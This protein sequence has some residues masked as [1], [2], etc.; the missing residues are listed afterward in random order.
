MVVVLCFVGIIR[1]LAVFGK[2][3]DACYGVLMGFV[4]DSNIVDITDT[5]PIH[6]STVE[7]RVGTHR[8]HLVVVCLRAQPLVIVALLGY[9]KVTGKQEE[10]DE[11][12]KSRKGGKVESESRGLHL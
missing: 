5:R 6:A 10:D 2:I 12:G 8:S 9:G 11:K 7:V 3:P 4:D 1:L